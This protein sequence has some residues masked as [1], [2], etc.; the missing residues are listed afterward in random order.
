MGRLSHGTGLFVIELCVHHDVTQAPHCIKSMHGSSRQYRVNKLATLL[1][2]HHQHKPLHLP[3][4]SKGKMDS[5]R[6]AEPE[7]TIN[8]ITSV[9]SLDNADA[10]SPERQPKTILL[11]LPNELNLEIIS[12]LP[13]PCVQQL[14]LTMNRRLTGL[15]IGSPKMRKRTTLLQN[16]RYIQ[17]AIPKLNG[18]WM[19]G[20]AFSEVKYL[21]AFCG[22]RCDSITESNLIN[23][24]GWLSTFSFPYRAKPATSLRTPA[25]LNTGIFDSASSLEWIHRL[26]K[27]TGRRLAA[28]PKVHRVVIS[29]ED[30][31]QLEMQA[32]AL[33][34]TLP[35]SFQKLLRS[36]NVEEIAP[37]IENDRSERFMLCLGKG[38]RRVKFPFFYSQGFSLCYD[39]DWSLPHPHYENMASELDSY[40]I[41][42]AQITC[43]DVNYRPVHRYS[44]FLDKSGQ[45]HCV[46]GSHFDPNG[47][48]GRYED[49]VVEDALQLLD[50]QLGIKPHSYGRQS[51]HEPKDRYKP[52]VRKPRQEYYWENLN[53]A[54]ELGFQLAGFSFDEFMVHTYYTATIKNIMQ[55]KPSEDLPKWL[56]HWLVGTHSEKGRS[57]LAA[58]GDLGI[59]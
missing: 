2:N 44:L 21:G 52:N 9:R 51:S 7:T 6:P 20:A 38:L 15:C 48:E 42:F 3:H 4:C 29:E 34:I 11:S 25:M 13:G 54:V 22:R 37:E 33:G 32:T 49:P 41:R 18:D 46:L 5:A 36:S 43:A 1:S 23:S 50:H 39:S 26:H 53:A 56:E 31:E 12:L 17:S 40:L 59:L 10:I 47:D 14:G 19:K 30:I 24:W 58:G 55:E 57:I 35:S 16:E 8:A 45:R 28:T 27:C